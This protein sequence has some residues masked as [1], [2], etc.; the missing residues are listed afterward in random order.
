MN[1]K[2]K[3]ELSEELALKHIS[4]NRTYEAWIVPTVFHNSGFSIIE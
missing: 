1:N 3:S 4:W 2:E